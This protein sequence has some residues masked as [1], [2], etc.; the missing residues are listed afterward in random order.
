MSRISKKTTSSRVQEEESE[1][2][3]LRTI[4]EREILRKSIVEENEVFF[5]SISPSK[6]ATFRSPIQAN[7]E[8]VTIQKVY[9]QKTDE[10]TKDSAR[11]LAVVTIQNA[12]D[13]SSWLKVQT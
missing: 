4:D 10:K 8:Q 12:Y 3:R 5:K 13:I 2:K 7:V 9:F 6:N 1:S 11:R